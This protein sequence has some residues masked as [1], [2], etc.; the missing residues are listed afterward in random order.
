MTLNKKNQKFLITGGTGFIGSKLVEELLEDGHKITILTRKKIVNDKINYIQN[1]DG[2]FD[3]DIVIN[4][5]GETISKYWSKKNKEK[6]YHSRID[7]TNKLAEIINN[8]KNPPSL[9]ISGSA[10]GFYGTSQNLV[11]DEN[12]KPATQNL[13]SQKICADWENAAQKISNKTRLAL[14]RTGVVV[15]KNGGII[16]KMLLPFKL[17]LGGKIG[18]GNQYLSWIA[19]D[20]VILAINHI[21]NN[22]NLSGTVNLSS[23]EVASNQSFAKTLALVLNRPC[24]FDMPEFIAKILFGKM[25]EE[26]LLAGQNVY[27][28]KLL[29]SGFKFQTASL[30]S[31]ILK[32]L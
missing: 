9:V 7:L 1:L 18:K 13:F 2:D 3:Y 24:F 25:G 22:E 16:K 32:A 29:A 12:S 8:S 6:I 5:A 11:F 15:G 28:K 23:P 10:I 27:P 21:I 30:K 19:L 31:A 20:D 17:G 4:L 26:L 14:I